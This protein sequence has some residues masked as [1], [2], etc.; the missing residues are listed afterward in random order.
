MT[1]TKELKK[2][3]GIAFCVEIEMD[4][5]TPN[6]RRVGDEF[7][8]SILKVC[9]ESGLGVIDMDAEFGDFSAIEPIEV[10]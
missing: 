7:A 9:K 10:E 3:I 5:Y 6:G 1:K 2:L 4:Y 8:K